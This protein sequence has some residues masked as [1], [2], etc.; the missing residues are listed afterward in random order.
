MKRGFYLRGVLI[1]DTKEVLRPRI[2]TKRAT[3]PGR[4][5]QVFANELVLSSIVQSK[6]FYIAIRDRPEKT[7]IYDCRLRGETNRCTVKL[8]KVYR[9]GDSRPKWVS[10]GRQRGGNNVLGY[11]SI[12]VVPYNDAKGPEGGVA[13]KLII[14]D[15]N[16]TTHPEVVLTFKRK[17][18]LLQLVENQ[19][20]R[21]VSITKTNSGVS[22]EYTVGRAIYTAEEKLNN[23]QPQGFWSK[24]MGKM[25]RKSQRR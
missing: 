2:K 1:S 10:P 9:P 5:A 8:V 13:V 14:V 20:L 19:V 7:L 21:D 11:K 25:R 16:D 22:Y 24:L 23:N 6:R 4:A 17:N 18:D 12:T 15:H 3:R